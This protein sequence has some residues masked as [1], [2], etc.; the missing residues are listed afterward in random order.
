MYVK[1][2][3][4]LSKIIEHPSVVDLD[5]LE[6]KTLYNLDRPL[7]ILCRSNIRKDK[8]SRTY[9]K[10]TF[11]KFVSFLLFS[12]PPGIFHPTIFRSWKLFS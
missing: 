9:T 8:L 4:I 11:M 10:P 3:F 7:K 1:S 6:K 12:K 2:V 5:F